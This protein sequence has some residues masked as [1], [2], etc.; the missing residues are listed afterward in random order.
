MKPK[1]TIPT[2]IAHLMQADNKT[3]L[4]VKRLQNCMTYLYTALHEQGIADNYD[5]AYDPSPTTIEQAV[6]RNSRAF[7]LD[8][9]GDLIYAR[10]LDTATLVKQYP[11]DG[12][13]FLPRFQQHIPKLY[14]PNTPIFAPRSCP[15][16]RIW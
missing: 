7:E 14:A 1:I 13:I 4:S 2:I 11:I 9:A 12:V 16:L 8:P 5:Q 15:F 3:Y 10:V 6:L